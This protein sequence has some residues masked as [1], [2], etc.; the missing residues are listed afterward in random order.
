[1]AIRRFNQVSHFEK[2][3]VQANHVTHP[4]AVGSDIDMPVYDEAFFDGLFQRD[5]GG[6][7]LQ[8]NIPAATDASAKLIAELNARRTHLAAKNSADVFLIDHALPIMNQIHDALQRNDLD[9]ATA[10]LQA[11]STSGDRL[12]YSLSRIAMDK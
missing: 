6:S 2:I 9:G 4:Q 7:I 1:V 10:L 8:R 11:D 3:S 5:F 12:R